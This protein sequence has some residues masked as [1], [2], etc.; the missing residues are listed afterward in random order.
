LP[1]TRYQAIGADIV[2]KERGKKKQ[3]ERERERGGRGRG[4]KKGF[5]FMR[6]TQ[7]ISYAR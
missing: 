4:N 3:R 6:S 7:R 5:T 1:V 2:E